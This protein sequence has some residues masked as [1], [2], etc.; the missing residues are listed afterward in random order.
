MTIPSIYYYLIYE[1]SKNLNKVENIDKCKLICDLESIL[2]INIY[3]KDFLEECYKKC[4]K[5]K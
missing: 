5:S 2:S 1:D 3:N 4:C